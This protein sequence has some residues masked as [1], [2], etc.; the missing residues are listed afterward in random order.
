MNKRKLSLSIVIPV[1]NEQDHL[2]NCLNSIADQTILPDEVIVVDNNSVDNSAAI[3]AAYPFV[4]VVREPKQGISYARDRGFDEAASQLIG[5]IDA[6]T[7]L[8]ETWVEDVMELYSSRQDFAFTGGG[9]FYNISLPWL[10]SWMLSQIAFR[11][12]RF[13]MGHFILW[14]SNMV[15][16]RTYWQQVRSN[17]CSNNQAIHE[18]LD[19][20]IHLHRL[21]CQITFIERIKV[22][23]E[24]KRVYGK[25]KQ[26]FRANLDLWPETLQAH[27]LKR[28]W[29]GRLGANFL[30]YGTYV[31]MLP[32]DRSIKAYRA[33]QRMLRTDP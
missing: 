25:S 8:S 2:K 22:G 12:N 30:Y 18:D 11:V 19:L 17:V 15:L 20:A 27:G 26:A 1:Y 10:N 24:M 3:A 16:P 21:G 13:I 4:R 7:I 9:Y 33:A 32:A 6:D 29:L 28:A 23:V 5:R 14:G 31:F